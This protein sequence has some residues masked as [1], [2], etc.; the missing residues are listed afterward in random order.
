MSYLLG[1][2]PQGPVV[3]SC[4]ERASY[5]GSNKTSNNPHRHTMT[6]CGAEKDDVV[7]VVIGL[8]VLQVCW[9]CLASKATADGS[10][11]DFFFLSP[12]LKR[13]IWPEK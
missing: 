10:F 4:L 1:E 6:R 5:W 8:Y 2:R 12:P 7:L 9:L 11:Y 3:A 13:R